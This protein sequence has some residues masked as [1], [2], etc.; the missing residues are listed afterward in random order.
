MGIRYDTIQKSFN[1]G[2][3]TDML[4]DRS[5][6]DKYHLGC[7]TAEN[8]IVSPYGP[9]MKMPGTRYVADAKSEDAVLVP[10][11]YSALD[12]Y[13]M[14]LGVRYGR[15]FRDGKPFVVG[16][17]ATIT[18]WAAATSYSRGDF[19]HAPV[20]GEAPYVCLTTHESS[21][22]FTDDVANRRWYQQIADAIGTGDV[23]QDD[24]TSNRVKISGHGG[25]YAGL[26]INDWVY[27]YFEHVYTTGFYK[28]VAV[29]PGT[30]SAVTIDLT[31]TSDTTDA[32]VNVIVF[33][34]PTLI[35][36]PK[37]LQWTQQ[38]DVLF[39][40]CPTQ[41]PSKL[42]RYG[43][44]E[45]I[46]E[47]S[48]FDYGPMRDVEV[49]GYVEG[50]YVCPDAPSPTAKVRL[51]KPDLLG[52]TAVGTTA[53]VRF[54]TD[55]YTGDDYEVEEVGAS[56]NDIDLTFVF[57]NTSNIQYRAVDCVASKDT[58]TGKLKLTKTGAFTTYSSGQVSLELPAWTT[59]VGSESAPV[60]PRFMWIP[61][62]YN[63]R[64]AVG[65]QGYAAN[66]SDVRMFSVGEYFVSPLYDSQ[67]NNKG[68][69]KTYI[70]SIDTV[71]N[72]A[73]T[74][75]TWSSYHV[76]WWQDVPK[77]YA[78]GLYNV[79]SYTNDYVILDTEWKYAPI[80][81]DS[82]G[83]VVQFPDVTFN[84]VSGEVTN[85]ESGCSV[86]SG[87]GKCRI[88]VTK[89]RPNQYVV[90]SYLYFDVTGGTDG[91]YPIIA[92]DPSNL[93]FDI[94]LAIGTVTLASIYMYPMTATLRLPVSLCVTRIGGRMALKSSTQKFFENRK[95]QVFLLRHYRDLTDQRL[96][97]TFS[98]GSLVS[99]V[100]YC[101][102]SWSLTTS[103]SWEGSIAVEWK[104]KIDD[105]WVVVF[106]AYRKDG[107]IIQTKDVETQGEG[108]YYR[109]RYVYIGTGYPTAS[110]ESTGTIQEGIYRVT[111]EGAADSYSA[112]VDEVQPAYKQD[113]WTATWK[114]GSF[115]EAN[116][117]PRAITFHEGRLCLAGTT[118]ETEKVWRSRVNDYDN[119]RDGLDDDD[120]QSFSINSNS[121][122]SIQWILGRGPL[123][124]G[125]AGSEHHM[126]GADGSPLTVK[127]V[128]VD[129]PSS[130]GSSDMMPLIAGN[131]IL[132]V[133]RHSRKI[134]EI[135]YSIESDSYVA[136]DLTE[137]APQVTESGV[138][139]LA[140]MQ[141]PYPIVW[142]VCDDGSMA[143]M[144]YER[145]QNV[146]GWHTHTAQNGSYKSA[147]VVPGE[148]GDD[149]Y[150][151]V[152]R[153]T[154][155]PAPG[156]G[157][158]EYQTEPRIERFD[159]ISDDP[160]DIVFLHCASERK[161][162]TPVLMYKIGTTAF[163]DPVTIDLADIENAY[164]S[165]SGNAIA[166]GDT[167]ILR[168]LISSLEHLD[169]DVSGTVCRLG[170]NLSG[171]TYELWDL[172]SNPVTLTEDQYDALV[173]EDGDGYYSSITATLEWAIDHI[174]V[175]CDY[176]LDGTAVAI[177]DGREVVDLDAVTKGSYAGF[178]PSGKYGRHIVVGIEYT[179]TLAPTPFSADVQGEVRSRKK[180]IVR[181]S[182]SLYNSGPCKH[183]YTES[184]LESVSGISPGDTFT[185]VVQKEVGGAH[186]TD[187]MM[188]LVSDTPHPL[189]ARSM[190]AKVEIGDDQ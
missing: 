109:V 131:T 32:H 140:Y 54:S 145:S 167:V 79:S 61:V 136:N 16:E 81:P 99:P 118:V 9:A 35:K 58:G 105:P 107:N 124:V 19:V 162:G 172:A 158:T 151:L 179:A 149:M 165:A 188:Y 71:N 164:D 37:H 156:S 111:E 159:P 146:F 173:L 92:I 3:L 113:R 129:N 96:N 185:G 23:S 160:E 43:R 142:A 180:R 67:G 174:R 139:Q 170:T 148:N 34:F 50:C 132:F 6:L 10:F 14:E 83:T 116:G 31:Y 171:D 168:N 187:A 69:H 94:D 85:L 68:D 182:T 133:Q 115:S 82:G 48:R 40:A 110:L 49:K 91:W 141:T 8:M 144:T 30:Y 11:L 70:L 27:V 152:N 137:L 183:G 26:N 53:G 87:G 64:T 157:E 15:L 47:E 114:E 123:F 38:N 186:V 22:V 88:T 143:G 150:V 98:S 166:V 177:L 86:T 122:D 78:Q 41:M 153:P 120:A 163:G 59:P 51:V 101:V 154:I 128:R 25:D 72:V 181:I 20:A 7:K 121:H 21:P 184:S 39:L 190:V 97:H 130:F 125:T 178:V 135:V 12:T 13:A 57:P 60:T 134:R 89:W 4:M 147:C 175:P 80:L 62:S 73:V 66:G 138:V 112:Y 176:P 189:I 28:V 126:R 103:G 18:T 45:W 33:E 161:R 46:H 42:K 76:G 108:A 95:G 155:P 2:I 56:Y 169:Y 55:R 36:D 119:F 5:D 104:E 100:L 17:S 84:G 106:S 65:L 102:K 24:P 29:T 74:N 75:F 52:A 44:Y 93:R 77:P 117:Y 90:G 1:A 63:G 127:N